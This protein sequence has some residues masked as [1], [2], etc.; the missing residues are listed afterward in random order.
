M[1]CLAE[2]HLRDAVAMIIV[3]AV[4]VAILSVV[5]VV[6]VAIAVVL[7]V[8]VAAAPLLFLSN[9]YMGEPCFHHVKLN[10]HG[11]K[12]FHHVDLNLHGGNHAFHHVNRIAPS[13]H[14]IL[15]GDL[16]A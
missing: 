6:P 12:H 11:G 7:S 1:L 2:L 10:L 9:F 13:K 3:V 5:V 14:Y 16:K 8:A 4:V 15:D